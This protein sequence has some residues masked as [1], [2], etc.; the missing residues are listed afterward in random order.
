MAHD[1]VREDSLVTLGGVPDGQHGPVRMSSKGEMY[2]HDADVL[3][4]LGG[5]SALTEDEAHGSG[6]AGYFML[7]VRNDGGGT[8][9]DA[10]GDYAPLQTDGSGNLR[11]AASVTINAEK[12]EDAVHGTGDTGSFVLA[13]RNDTLAALAGAD[14]DYAPFQVNADGALYSAVSSVPGALQGPGNPTVDSFA[15][16]VI[17]VAAG[18]TDAS[19]IAAPGASKQLWIMGLS[20]TVD[21]DATTVFFESAATAL[22]GTYTFNTGQGIQKP[23][24]GNFAQPYYKC[25]TNEAFTLTNT[26]GAIDGDVQYAIVS[27]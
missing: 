26:V 17:D 9:V 20:F 5:S 23:L 22:T 1:P 25:G 14:G 7:A 6:D 13:V 4:A 2:V 12:A 10:D 19:L 11:V 3:A 8:M 24:S 16:A 27:V 18:Q 21:T 15:S